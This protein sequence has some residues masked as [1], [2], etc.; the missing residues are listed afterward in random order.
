MVC[1]RVLIRL[2]QPSLRLCV[3][4]KRPPDHVVV[5]DRATHVDEANIAARHG[6]GTT[7]LPVVNAGKLLHIVVLCRRSASMVDDPSTE[8]RGGKLG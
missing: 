6:C 5:N 4:R 2:K 1:S 7:A 3:L 8:I